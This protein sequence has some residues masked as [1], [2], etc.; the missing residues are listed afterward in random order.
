VAS[1]TRNAQRPLAAHRFVDRVDDHRRL[2]V[3]AGARDP[4][5]HGMVRRRDEPREHLQ[6]AADED[7]E[8]RRR[9][10]RDQRPLRDARL[11]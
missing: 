1:E 7:V 8:H 3:R 9:V 2:R 11:S 6:L 4:A 5:V 10:E